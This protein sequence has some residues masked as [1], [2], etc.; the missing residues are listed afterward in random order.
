VSSLPEARHPTADGP[1]DLDRTEAIDGLRTVLAAIGYTGE[2]IRNLLGDDA[3]Q[4]RE[5]DVPV[6]LRRLRS[7]SRL[8]TAIRLF[9]L[10][11]PLPR[12]EVERALAP[13][14]ADDLLRLGVAVDGGGTAVQAAVRLVP[15]ADLL[16]AGNRYP[17]ETA[18]AAPADYVAT[19]TA[20]S[21]ILGCLTVRRPVTT[22]LDIGTGSGVQ[23]LWLA[24]HSERVVAVDVNRR[25]LNLAAFNA[26]LNGITNIEFREGSLFEPVAGERFDLIVCNAP[27]VV[28]PDFHYAYRD[29]GAQSDAFN[30]RLVREAPAHLVEGGFAH[31]LVGW[32]LGDADWT[33]RPR[34][35]VE[36]SGCDCWLLLGV[37]RDAVTHAAVWN[38][39]LSREPERYAET[40][41]RWIGYLTG[42]AAEA[43]A[44][45]AVIL[46]RKSDRSNWFRA[47]PIPPGQ[48]TP[49]SDHVLRVFAAHDHLAD[50]PDETALLDERL[51]LVDSVRIE[52]E[53][54]CR[55]GGYV[56]EEMTVVLDEGL[57]FRA[58]VDQNTATLLPFLD[59]ARSLR[60]AILA[61]STARGVDSE[62]TDL[63]ATGALEV[64][65]KMFE[66]GFLT[67]RAAAEVK[68]ER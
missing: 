49:A 53:L 52:Q 16:L 17:D 7:G 43:V 29:S 40:L 46:R 4:S 62:D 48:P 44:E 63:F 18:G 28:S 61:A 38:E 41:D 56:V 39:E 54:S 15:H 50:L 57:G 5:R 60:E 31:L 20:P 67:R 34:A 47:D 26:R 59:G 22:S 65:R 35:W 24:R 66:L 68:G 14:S 1:I 21:A 30:E 9:F 55:D 64:A 42:L 13:I 12:Q 45:G 19:V 36:G 2:A 32:I 27:Y 25:A 10:G 8:N 23:A 33:A 3:Y 37:Q 51:A 58:G 6:H 11:V